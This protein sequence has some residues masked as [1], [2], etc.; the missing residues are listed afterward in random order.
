M[1][2]LTIMREDVIQGLLQAL[3][4][5]NPHARERCLQLIW[6]SDP[7]RPERTSLK[8]D[9]RCLEPV[10]SIDAVLEMMDM[11]IQKDWS[12]P[13]GLLRTIRQK[14]KTVQDEFVSTCQQNENQDDFA[15]QKFTF[16]FNLLIF[17]NVL[18]NNNSKR[19][20]LIPRHSGISH[21]KL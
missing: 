15:F 14:L 21:T 20:L 17:A 5:R 13:Y 10:L 16:L 1:S 2:D 12:Q 7:M 6:P 9:I 18:Y 11:E 19:L 3:G 4:Q 8:M